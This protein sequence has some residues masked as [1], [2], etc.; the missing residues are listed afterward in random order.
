VFPFDL[1]SSG[2]PK[3][4]SVSAMSAL[5]STA[6]SRIDVGSVDPQLMTHWWKKQEALMPQ[7]KNTAVMNLN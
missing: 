4:L 1:G 5:H 2:N 6:A 7:K 3:F